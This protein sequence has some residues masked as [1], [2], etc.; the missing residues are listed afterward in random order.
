MCIPKAGGTGNDAQVLGKTEILPKG[1][2]CSQTFL[3]SAF[4]SEYEAK[5]L[6][7]YMRTRFLRA[8][9]SSVKIGPDAMSNVYRYVPLQD[10]TPNSDIDWSQDVAGIDRQLYAKYGLSADE[11]AFIEERIKPM[12]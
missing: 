11:V 4:D 9:V 5:A 2:V 6:S 12:E 8:V 3:Y 7:T 10:F 1:S